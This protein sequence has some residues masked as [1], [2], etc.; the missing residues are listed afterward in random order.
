MKQN[1]DTERLK[2]QKLSKNDADFIYELVNTAGWI[3]NI[4]DRHVHTVADAQSYIQKIIDNPSVCYWTVSLQNNGPT[5]GVITL[6]KRDY[7]EHHDIGFAFLPQHTQHG[8]A[9][10]ATK[11]VLGHLIKSPLH[12]R[13]LAITI[14]DNHSSIR[15][16]EKLGF[17]F[18]KEIE[19]EQLLRYT[20]TTGKQSTST[21]QIDKK[22]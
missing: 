16:L 14:R 13:I 22:D 1:F 20:M 8:Y 9:Y 15:L 17:S 3:K 19:T 4:G 7:L 5:I 12:D 18:E 21:T 2:L 6:I 10:E 11:T